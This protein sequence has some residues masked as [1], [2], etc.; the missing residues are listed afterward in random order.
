[1]NTNN[2]IEDT[3]KLDYSDYEISDEVLEE[4]NKLN[5]E[6]IAKA[7]MMKLS[8]NLDSEEEQKVYKK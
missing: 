6:V 1:M 7:K 3:K 4:I 5:E 8:D 2:Q